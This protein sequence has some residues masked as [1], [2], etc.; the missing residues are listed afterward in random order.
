M[1]THLGLNFLVKCVCDIL[2][3]VFERLKFSGEAKIKNSTESGEGTSVRGVLRGL[4]TY[5]PVCDIASST[6]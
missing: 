2:N 4:T 5:T 3:S 1:G 6:D